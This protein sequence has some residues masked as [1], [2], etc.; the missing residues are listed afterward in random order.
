MDHV[1]EAIIE[2]NCEYCDNIVEVKEYMKRKVVVPKV[3]R[4]VENNLYVQGIK[5]LSD[6]IILG[7][8]Q[9]EISE[10]DKITETS[11]TRK[12]ENGKE[13]V[14]ESNTTSD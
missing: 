14:A 13:H 7:R 6:A 11:A 10:S 12:T 4:K 1:W 9:E 2:A 3:K 8:T 5:I